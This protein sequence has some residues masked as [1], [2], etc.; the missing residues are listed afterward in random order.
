M[1]KIDTKSDF[2]TEEP[3]KP[4]SHGQT[5]RAARYN[6]TVAVAT[7]VPF[8]EEMKRNYIIEI[9]IPVKLNA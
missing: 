3:D 7:V 2:M 6:K 9:S 4:A 8:P 1:L 5:R